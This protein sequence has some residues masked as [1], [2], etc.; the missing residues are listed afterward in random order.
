MTVEVSVLLEIK[1]NLHC[2]LM[3]AAAPSTTIQVGVLMETEV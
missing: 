2:Q 3:L 1:L